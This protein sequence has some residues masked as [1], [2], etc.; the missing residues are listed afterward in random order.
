[1]L[2]SLAIGLVIMDVGPILS[3]MVVVIMVI[4]VTLLVVEE[5]VS[6][7]SSGSVVILMPNRRQVKILLNEKH[8]IPYQI[9]H[10]WDHRHHN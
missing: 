3:V 10:N 8:L 4:V 1:M 5:A 6:G 7:K 2:S 9:N